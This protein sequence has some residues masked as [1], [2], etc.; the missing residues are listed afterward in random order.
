MLNET[1]H[2]G[3]G[4]ALYADRIPL[5]EIAAAVGTPVYVYSLRRALANYRAIETAFAPLGA[6]IHYSAKANS[7]LAVLRTLVNAG[8]GIDCVSGGEIDRALKAG[9]APDNIVFAGVGKT[10]DDLAFAVSRGVGWINLENT[11][12]ADLLNRIAGEQGRT[13]RVAVRLNPDVSAATHQ[14][15]ATGHGS[16]KFGLPADAVRALYDRAADLPY[17]RFQGIHVHI[18]SQ[19]GETSATANAVAAALDVIAPYPHIRTIDIG[20]GLPVAYA[21]G[22]DLPPY[23]AFAAALAP[24]LRGYNVLMEPGRAIIADAG[25]L[26]TRVLYLKDQPGERFAIVDAGMNDLIRPMLY[27]AHHEIVPLQRA[28][29]NAASEPLQV[30]GPVC[31]STDV[32]AKRVRLS[33]VAPG[34]LLAVMTVGAYGYG[35]ASNYNARPRPAEAVIDEAGESW[36][37]ARRRETWDDLAALETFY[38]T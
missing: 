12:E 25:V 7:S 37:L 14:H 5:H 16:A 11:D 26:L 24:L 13:T 20:G 8:A 10:A 34:D 19:L 15:I 3:D 33:G 31:E 29:S 28:P 27:D 17:L 1:F 9:A 32:L 30:V 36:R 18:G 22:V 35:M 2:Y 4:D 38:I 6:H 21:P 23:S